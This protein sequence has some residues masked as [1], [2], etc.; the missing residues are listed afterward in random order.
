MRFDIISL[1]PESFAA[2]FGVSILK[3]AETSGLIEIHTHNLRDFA[4]D[5]HKTVDDTPYGGGAGMVLKV[6]PLAEAI[7]SVISQQP[8]ENKGLRT[9]TILFSAKGKLFTQ[10]D[11]RRLATY[12]RLIFVCGRYE[13]VDERVTEQWIDEEIS[14]GNYVL[15]GGELPA[16]IVTDAVAR[17]IPGVLGNSES[18]ETE[19][20][21]EEGVV[22]YPQYTKP[23]EF[24]GLRVPEVLLSGHHAEIAKWR[25]EQSGKMSEKRK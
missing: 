24:R 2:Y 8:A 1:F 11:A 18:A 17:L 19:S 22:E 5:K 21:S 16:M 14:I 10:A 13:G 20:H 7:K 3:R 9:R 4:H 25:K 12:E 23:E 15:T 6:E